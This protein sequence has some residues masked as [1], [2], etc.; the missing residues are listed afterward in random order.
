MKIKRIYIKKY[1]NIQEQELTFNDAVGYLALIG[2]NGSGKSNWLEA[3]SMIFRSLYS[4][5]VHFT[6]ELEYEMWGHLY[7]ITHKTKRGGGF[8]T[9]Y[10]EDD[11]AIRKSAAVFPKVIACYSGESNRLWSIAYKDYYNQFF[12][13]AIRNKIEYPEMLYVNKYFWSIALIALM[14]SD[15]PQLKDF[16][17]NHLGIENLD[18]ITVSFE[19]IPEN[20]SGFQYNNVKE[21]LLLLQEK[22]DTV[23]MPMAE[24]ASLA[25]DYRNN[26]DY[27]RKL[28]NYLFIASLP[29]TNEEI[30][31]NKAISKINVSVDGINSYGFS[32]GEQK[33]ILIKCLTCLLA[34]ENTLLVLDEPDAHVH[35]ANKIDIVTAISTYNGQ[36]ILTSHSPVVVNELKPECIRYVDKGSICNTDKISTIRRV[37][38]NAISLIDGAFILSARKLVVTEGPHDID[39][40]K[41]AVKKLG[42]LDSKYLKLNSVAFVFQGS[43]D[44]TQSYFDEVIAP[45]INEMDKILFIFDYDAGQGNNANGQKGHKVIENVKD[46]YD[47]HLDCLYYS[48]DYTEAPSTFYIEDYFV[49][50]F[51]P[52]AKTRIEGLSVPPT[53]RE[54]K[55]INGVSKKIK[56]EIE[57]NYS[58]Y[59][60]DKYESFRPLLDKLMEVFNLVV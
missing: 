24:V 15:E 60:K 55:S 39:Y 51:F 14:C 50:D 36:T 22:G 20:I 33:M 18:N 17:Q 45:I 29:V 52:N 54:L 28:F 30:P 49:S 11:K 12:K 3:V 21:L 23:T 37:S 31:I 44:N 41:T 8:I 19:L 27:C 13:D 56:D 43:A 9:S 53:Y 59:D 38:G 35:V 6:Y 40:I 4:K 5:E 7:I 2:Q 1:K 48:N 42:E 58:N 10:R 16:L 47:G 32:E 34:D 26:L 25:I 57:Q 46:Q